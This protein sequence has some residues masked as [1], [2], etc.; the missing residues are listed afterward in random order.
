M[1]GEPYREDEVGMLVQQSW[2]D[3][4]E[5]GP[6]V[7][8]S[9]WWLR[10]H[11][12]R[13][14]EIGEV[15]RPPRLDD[16]STAIT[17]SCLIARRR[18]AAPSRDELERIEPCDRRELAGLATSVRLLRRELDGHRRGGALARARAG[19]R[20]TILRSRVGPRALRMRRRLRRRGAG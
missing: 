14:F 5:G 8:H 13:A 4:E 1:L 6:S 19:L 15:R 7:F 10:E 2:E 11:W 9:E 16:G 18:D 20:R 12:G 3:P 17:H